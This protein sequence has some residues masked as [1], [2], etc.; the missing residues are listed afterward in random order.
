M[1]ANSFI[2]LGLVAALALGTILLSVLTQIA[3]RKVA[4]RL[5]RMENEI[6]EIKQDTEDLEKA[7]RLLLYLSHQMKNGVAKSSGNGHR[8]HA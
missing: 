5:K 1:F 6:A 3:V 8:I 4:S 7:H 2:I